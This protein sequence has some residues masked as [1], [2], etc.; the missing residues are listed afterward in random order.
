MAHHLLYQLANLCLA[1]AFI[2]PDDYRHH[3]KLFRS[4]EIPHA[5][6]HTLTQSQTPLITHAVNYAGVCNKTCSYRPKRF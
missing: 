2:I 6:T 3:S 4:Q 5:D 1:A